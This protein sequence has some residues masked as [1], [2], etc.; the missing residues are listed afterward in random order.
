MASVHDAT[1]RGHS[2]T[3]KPHRPH[4]RASGGS[5]RR[6]R[7]GEALI[8]KGSSAKV[9]GLRGPHRAAKSGAALMMVGST[10][11]CGSRSAPDTPVHQQSFEP[12]S[13]TSVVVQKGG[14][15]LQ[16]LLRTGELPLLKAL[17]KGG[18]L[19]K[20]KACRNPK[21]KAKAQV[22]AKGQRTKRGWKG[23]LERV[24]ETQQ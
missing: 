3:K 12:K 21:C 22:Q 4:A 7:K 9:K 16:T 6:P 20:M 13:E 1:S 10:K 2:V 11:S 5:S 15:K 8:S 17:W 14:R 23:K 18:R 19:S 24:E